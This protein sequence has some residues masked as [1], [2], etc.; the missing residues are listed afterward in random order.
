MNDERST[1]KVK[2]YHERKF[3]LLIELV[4]DPTAP[5]TPTPRKPHPHQLQAS[6]YWSPGFS[7]SG[8]APFAISPPHF[9][10]FTSIS[11]TL[12]LPP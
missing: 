2:R 12:P 8:K 7:R 5:Q 11:S 9:N 4:L 3:V 1:Q 10:F 6:S